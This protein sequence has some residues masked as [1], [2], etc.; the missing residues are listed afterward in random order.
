MKHVFLGRFAPFHLGHKMVVDYIIS[1]FGIENCL[2]LIGSSNKIDSRTPY[3][4]TKRR[5]I[6]KRFYP[7][8]EILALPD[9]ENDKKWLA[10][11]KNLERKTH[12]KFIFYGGSKKDL[13]VLSTTFETHIAINRNTKGLGI[14]ATKIRAGLMPFAV[15]TDSK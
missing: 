14:S 7:L 8:L 3:S 2:L 10:S 6:I 11:L 5:N 9:V 1:R 4:F 13:S 15:L 12:D